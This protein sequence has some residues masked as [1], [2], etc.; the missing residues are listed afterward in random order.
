VQYLTQAAVKLPSAG[1][2]AHSSVQH[3]LWLVRYCP[4]CTSK[5]SV[6]VIN[7]WIQFKPHLQ[8]FSSRSGRRKWC[9]LT[10][11]SSAGKWL[12]KWLLGSG[13]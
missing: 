5:N 3:M 7:P 2:D 1:D 11:P 13:D 6:A 9:G 10:D 4:W 12:G 8:R